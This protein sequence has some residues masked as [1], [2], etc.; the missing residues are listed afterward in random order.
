MPVTHPIGVVRGSDFYF[1]VVGDGKESVHFFS[2]I[3]NLPH[4][5]VVVLVGAPVALVI[6]RVY[7]HNVEG[8]SSRYWLFCFV[9]QFVGGGVR[10]C[11]YW[12]YH[13]ISSSPPSNGVDV[14]CSHGAGMVTVDCV[15]SDGSYNGGGDSGVVFFPS[16]GQPHV[17]HGVK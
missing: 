10:G 4:R 7:D 11:A 3:N 13:G 8:V 1:R 6:V 16:D 15:S 12:N 17:P 14:R 2:V 9:G 5:S